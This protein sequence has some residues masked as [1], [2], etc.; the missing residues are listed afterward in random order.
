MGR[1]GAWKGWPITGWRRD[2]A[3]AREDVVI[4]EEPLE[5]QA[6][7]PGDGTMEVF[8]VAVT[9]R[10]PGD[11]EEL[12]LGFFYT[13]G[14]IDDPQPLAHGLSIE[15]PSPNE[16][17]V[18]LPP[19]LRID[20][21][22]LT[23]HFYMTSS[24]GVCGKAAIEAVFVQGFPSLPEDGPVIPLSLLYD[25]PRR[26]REAQTLF[27]RTGGLHAAA[28]FDPEGRLRWL[29]E[30]VGRH[31]AVDKVI[32]AALREGCL[33]LGRAVMLVS[34]RAGFEIAQKTLRAGIPILAALGAPSSLTLE[35][36][37][38]VGMTVVGFL[39]E[40]GANVY[41]APWRIHVHGAT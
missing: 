37:Q 21:Q 15:R 5:I 30:D 4:V 3:E 18:I 29:R 7:V 36:A 34:G 25:L 28:I 24:C 39:R 40:G 14:L 11:D 33:P 19:E 2:H 12:A 41:T 9:M 8:P 16:A 20:R 10:T 6:V 1:D 13:E 27:R 35:L 26:L 32:G 31:N 22:R 17:R 38:A 23:R